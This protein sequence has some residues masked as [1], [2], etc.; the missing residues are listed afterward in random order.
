MRERSFVRNSTLAPG[1]REII[2][3]GHASMC[4]PW[5]RLG[6]EGYDASGEVREEYEFNL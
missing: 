6:K 5:T 2:C 3:G 1:D 4:L